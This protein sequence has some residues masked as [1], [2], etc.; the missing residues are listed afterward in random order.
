[1]IIGA[2]VWNCPIFLKF[3]VDPEHQLTTDK[4]RYENALWVP[5]E[6]R[7]SYRIDKA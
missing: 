3:S 1:M 6:G 5:D 2:L 4:K 7:N